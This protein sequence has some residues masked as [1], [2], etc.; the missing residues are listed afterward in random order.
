MNPEAKKLLNSMGCPICKSQLDLVGFQRIASKDYNFY[1][2]NEPHHYGI[3]L[4]H[5]DIVPVI[6]SEYLSVSEYPYKY[7]I[8]QYLI[9]TIKTSIGIWEIDLEGNIQTTV[10]KIEFSGKM[11]DFNNSNTEKILNRIKTLLVFQ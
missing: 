6:H 2:V 3:Y 10:K 4:N 7:N 5:W 8:Y 11:F 1:C 9:G